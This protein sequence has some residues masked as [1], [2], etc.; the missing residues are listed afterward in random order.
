MRCARRLPSARSRTCCTRVPPTCSPSP[1]LWRRSKGQRRRSRCA[2]PRLARPRES[3]ER[4]G[5]LLLQ[6]SEPCLVI[7]ELRALLVDV[8]L[9]RIDGEGI[10]LEYI[11]QPTCFGSC[12]VARRA[13]PAREVD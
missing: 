7:S 12:V 1:A 5:G 8:T 9:E 3:W 4:A 10:C 11:L 13:H 2:A 6:R